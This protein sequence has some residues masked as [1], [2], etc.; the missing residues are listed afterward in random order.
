MR[1]FQE[2]EMGFHTSTT[3][4]GQ[5][6]KRCIKRGPIPPSIH[7]PMYQVFFFQRFD[8]SFAF[9][10]RMFLP[11]RK[12]I[13]L[14]QDVSKVCFL[15]SCKRSKNRDG[16]PVPRSPSCCYIFLCGH[17]DVC[18]FQKIQMIKE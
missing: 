2:K 8:T 14:D 6:N 3:N 9:Q 17:M 5:H 15:I 13:L 16:S 1:L 12:E 10:I 18:T 7:P 4:E 11:F